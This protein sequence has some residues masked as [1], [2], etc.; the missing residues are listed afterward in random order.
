MRNETPGE[1]F[2]LMVER[3]EFPSGG[4]SRETGYYKTSKMKSQMKGMKS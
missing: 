1:E 3:V 4:K 2:A